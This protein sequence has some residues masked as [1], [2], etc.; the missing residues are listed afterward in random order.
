MASWVRF[1]TRQ[2]LLSSAFFFFF[3]F[4]LSPIFYLPTCTNTAAAGL[5]WRKNPCPEEQAFKAMRTAVEKGMYCWNAGEFYGTPEYNSMTILERYFEKYPE[6]AEKV[7]V[8]FKGG[9]DLV[10]LH[11]DGS[12]ENIRKSLD[13]IIAQLKGR[14]KVDIYECARRDRNVP[15]EETLRVIDKEYVQTGKVGGIALSEV[16]AATIHEAVKITKIVAVEVE[17][18]LWSTDVLK[19]GIAEACAQYGIPIL[20]YAPLSSGVSCCPFRYETIAGTH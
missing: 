8:S 2:Y 18:S 3:F 5:T 19:N 6:D 10:N 13:N 11:P 1:P 12:P 7:V 14:K 17:L 15:L 4:C 16:S 9:V 20:A